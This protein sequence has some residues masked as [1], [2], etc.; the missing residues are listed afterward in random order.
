MKTRHG[1]G[2]EKKT[3]Q[4]REG[5]IIYKECANECVCVHARVRPRK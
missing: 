5:V 1:G 4:Q 2:L 3:D